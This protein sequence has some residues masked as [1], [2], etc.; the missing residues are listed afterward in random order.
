MNIPKYIE[1]FRKFLELKNY[2]KNTIE[3]YTC[4]IRLFLSEMNGKFTEPAK[5]NEQA[6]V[7]YLLR[8]KSHN[9]NKHAQC[10]LRLFYKA[11]IHQPKKFK[12]IPYPKKEKKLPQVIDKDYLLGCIEKIQNVK[13]KAIIALA[14]STGMRVSEICNL[15]ISDIDSK[16][17]IITIR[18]SKGRKD[19]IVALSEKILQ[20]LRKYYI[21]F[22]PKEFLFNGQ[23]DLKYSS[24]SCNQIVKKYIGKNYHFHELRHSN[25]TALL[26]AGTDIR[27]IQKHL[28]HSSSKTTEIYTHVSTNLLNKMPLPI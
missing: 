25:A 2:S 1:S 19:R 12:F 4:Q 27:I 6:I 18:Q 11:I 14:Y 23:F 26:E 20:I 24:R 22:K 21:E 13:H 8:F 16:R 3:N 10:A 9:T 5:V 28:G 15:K 17:M 7:D